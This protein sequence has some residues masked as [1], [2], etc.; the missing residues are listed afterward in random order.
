MKPKRLAKLKEIVASSYELTAQHFNETR[1][2]VA[3]PDFIWAVNQIGSDDQVFDAGC[4]NGRLLD[5]IRLSPEQYLGVDQSS[6]LLAYARDKH[7]GYNFIQA[8]LSEA[9]SLVAGKFSLIFCSAVISHIPG[10]KERREVLSSLL[11][12]IYPEGR[13]IISFWKLEGRN[14]KKL[15]NTWW[16]KITGCHSYGWRDL[17]FPWK[18]AKGEEISPRYYYAFTKRH[19]RYELRRAGWEIE[20]VRNDRFN[21]WVIARPK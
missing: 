3:A 13:L 11:A 2:K 18:N 14:R 10:E 5:Y 15:Y 17:I 7:P 21:Y 8:D 9:A 20:S 12:L 16:K 6:A 19:F 4:G 1:S